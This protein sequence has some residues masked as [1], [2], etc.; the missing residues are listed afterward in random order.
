[1]KKKSLKEY[2][3][4]KY[5]AKFALIMGTATMLTACDGIGPQI[6]GE[7]SVPEQKQENVELEGDVSIA[8]P[9]TESVE[10]SGEVAVEDYENMLESCE[11][12][13]NVCETYDSEIMEPEIAGG[14]EVISEEN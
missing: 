11:E 4:P 2:Q 7:M 8:E 13:E 12:G 9:E 14:L 6:S 10:I 5:M 3:I 1:M